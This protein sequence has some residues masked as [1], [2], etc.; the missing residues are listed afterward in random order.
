MMV[1]HRR[2]GRHRVNASTASLTAVLACLKMEELVSYSLR[3]VSE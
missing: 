1:P 3:L 2:I